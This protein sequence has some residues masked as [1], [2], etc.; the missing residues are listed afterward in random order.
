MTA[1][2]DALA[3]LSTE[4][5]ETVLSSS[6]MNALAVSVFLTLNLAVPAP[7]LRSMMLDDPMQSLDDIHLLGLIDL[8]RR[9]KDGRQLI[10]S[11]HDAKFG[12]LLA[13]KLRPVGK[14]ERTVVIELDGWRREGPLVTQRNV[15]ADS[16]PLRIAV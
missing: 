12:H 1:I 4:S 14:D 11:T 3:D 6:Q 5:P 9:T 13:R 8:L 15:L 16:A 7:P 10:L 2:D